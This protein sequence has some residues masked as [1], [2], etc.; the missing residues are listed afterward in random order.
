MNNI[1]YDSPKRI[2]IHKP[3]VIVIAGLL[4]QFL[5]DPSI[6]V[7]EFERLISQIVPALRK[8]KDILIQTF[9]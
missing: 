8:I 4:D 3:K 6:E 7:E 9:F 5:Q 2:E 1:I